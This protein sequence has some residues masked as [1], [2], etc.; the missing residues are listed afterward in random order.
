MIKKE[1]K[2]QDVVEF[3]EL[4]EQNGIEIIIDGGWGVDAL[5]GKQTRI[6]EDLDIALQHKY[7]AI[8]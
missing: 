1:F 8:T 3:L 6:H 7:A 2:A 5:L 4:C